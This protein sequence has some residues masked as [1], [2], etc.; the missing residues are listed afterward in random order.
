MV[1]ITEKGGGLTL[2]KFD[3]TESDEEILKNKLMELQGMASII[4][5]RLSIIGMKKDLDRRVMED[6]D[7][8]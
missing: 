7:Y 2:I 5:A 6:R 8:F 1:F 3:L 4:E